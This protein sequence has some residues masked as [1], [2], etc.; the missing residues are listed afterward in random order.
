ML[1]LI[2][3]FGSNF[4]VLVVFLVNW[5]V[6]VM[7]T[8]EVREF[9]SKKFADRHNKKTL[10]RHLDTKPITEVERIG[11][12]AWLTGGNKAEQAAVLEYHNRVQGEKTTELLYRV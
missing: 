5:S 8:V 9:V 1:S 7:R 3:F 10:Y 4:Y 6:L 12:T 11:A 2:F